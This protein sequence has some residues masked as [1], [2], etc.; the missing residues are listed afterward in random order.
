L[1][2][3]ISIETKEKLK[4]K[5]EGGANKKVLLPGNSGKQLVGQQVTQRK[6][7]SCYES[8]HK[9]YNEELNEKVGY[10]FYQTAGVR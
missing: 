3:K 1:E 9:G 7:K 4:Q 10:I 8:S 2:K 6:K 5:D